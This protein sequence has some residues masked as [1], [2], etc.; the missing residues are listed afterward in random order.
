M[1]AMKRLVSY[2]TRG[3][4]EG[5]PLYPHK[6]KDGTYVASHTRFEVDYIFVDNEKELEALVRAGYSA[7]MSCPEIK[8]S[9]SLIMPRSIHYA[10]T[11]TPT[12]ALERMLSKLSAEKDLESDSITKNRKEQHFLRAFLAGG[13]KD[14]P[15][16]LC[17]KEYPLEFLVAAHIKRRS[18][19]SNSEKLDFQNVAA[20]MCKSGCDDLFEKGYVYVSEGRVQKNKKRKTTPALDGCIERIAGKQVANWPSSEPYY[21]YHARKFGIKT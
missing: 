13:Q 16:I 4:H 3:P 7:R 8:N 6:H 19:C 9:P 21:E 17:G 20:L 2:I 1:A 5:K 18:D 12:A 10:D 11:E 14:A 15:C